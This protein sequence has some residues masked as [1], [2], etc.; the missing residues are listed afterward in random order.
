MG[1]RIARS[2]LML[3][4]VIVASGCKDAGTFFSKCE[5][6]ESFE[7][8]YDDLTSK[9]K[10]VVNSHVDRA[11]SLL[12]PKPGELEIAAAINDYVYQYY[13]RKDNNGT[14]AKMLTE[15]HA[16]C[17]GAAVTMAEMLYSVNIKSRLAYLVGIPNQGSHSLVEVYFTNGTS[18]LF[19]PTY[20]I[21]WYDKENNRPVSIL[22]LLSDPQLSNLFLYKSINKK[23]QE[24]KDAVNPSQGFLQTYQNKRSY[25]EQY[26]DPYLCFRQRSGGGVAGDD[27]KT[28]VKIPME[29]GVLYGD[30]D[31]SSNVVTPWNKLALL[32]NKE[33]KYISWAYMLGEVA[34]YSVSHIYQFSKLITGNSYN[35]SLYYAEANASIL[36]IQ[37]LN[38]H[39]R[40]QENDSTFYH[41]IEKLDYKKDIREIRKIDIP[42]TAESQ[43]VRIIIATE[44]NIMLTAIESNLLAG[45]P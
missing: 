20:G 39:R 35:L 13:I 25:K 29:P 38:G 14:T 31:G 30:K 40:G 7:R 10:K 8:Q 12:P 42:F 18:G 6:K 1:V 41:Q 45:G 22:K 44:G 33:G 26:Y 43:D 32:Q 21:L 16:S 23:R 15:G 4:F 2:V 36:S 27:Y 19:D 5:K 37:I 9:E 17:G 3:L 34:D 24:L 11:L 28:F